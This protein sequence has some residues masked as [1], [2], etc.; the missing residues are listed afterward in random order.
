MLVSWYLPTLGF[1][2]W[3]CAILLLVF[4]PVS[5]WHERNWRRT[6]A[7]YAVVRREVGATDED[8]PSPG[9]VHLM[10]VQPGLLLLASTMLGLMVGLAAWAALLWPRTPPGF[11]LPVNSLDLPFLWS[12]VVAGIA[13]VIAGVAIAL[14][15]RS[16]PMSRVAYQVRRAI[17][18]PPG[19]RANRFARALIVDPGVPHTGS[20]V[21]D[22]GETS[23]PSGDSF[24]L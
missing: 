1:S 24:D 16:N 7:V 11:E 3:P 17:Y 12:M 18:A 10:G 5:I 6:L 8:W 15:V 20:G 23:A 22:A 13:A 14:D 19:E 9:L 2:L 21:S 4:I